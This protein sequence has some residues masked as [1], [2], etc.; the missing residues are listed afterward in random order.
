[1]NQVT[2]TPV[3]L[4][5]HQALEQRVEK[6]EKILL[7]HIEQELPVVPD[8][9]IDIHALIKELQD[10]YTQYPSFAKSLRAERARERKREQSHLRSRRVRG[11]RSPAKRKGRASRRQLDYTL[12]K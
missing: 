12:A 6:L 11:V 10:E 1:M 5:D 3:M 2:I 8:K 4:A 9:Q 7:P